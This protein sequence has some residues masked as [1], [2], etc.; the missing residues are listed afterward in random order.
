[1]RQNVSI[2]QPMPRCAE[3]GK[4]LRH[5]TLKVTTVLCVEC[6]DERRYRKQAGPSAQET[7]PENL[8]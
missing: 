1:M 4:P 5:I 7:T 2:S 3:C 8:V 6:Y